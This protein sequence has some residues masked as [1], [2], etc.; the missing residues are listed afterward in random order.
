M[1]VRTRKGGNTV[2]L[3]Q[4]LGDLT[5]T[6]LHLPFTELLVPADRG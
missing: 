1:S 2:L 4:C 5:K 6:L 3:V